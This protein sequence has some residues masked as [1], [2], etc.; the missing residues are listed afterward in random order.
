MYSKMAFTYCYKSDKIMRMIALIIFLAWVII[1]CVPALLSIGVVGFDKTEK[2]FV[3]V[4]NWCIERM[5]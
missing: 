3:P 2:W 4:L 5:E 1:T